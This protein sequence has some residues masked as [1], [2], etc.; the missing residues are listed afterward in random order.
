MIAPLTSWS[1]G[2]DLGQR[3]DRSALATLS[4]DWSVQGRN[5][6]DWSW[7]RV[8]R[9][10][11]R[12]IERFPLGAPYLSFSEA[13]AQRY[14]HIAALTPALTQ[15]QIHL[16]VDAGGPGAP[17]IEHLR[18]ARLR[19][20]L[21]AI[22]LT[23]GREPG[24]TA[25]GTLTVPRRVLLSN[26]ILLLDHGRLH[27][28]HDLPGWP[29]LYEELL[30]L[31][32]ATWHPDKSTAHDDMVIALAIAAWRITRLHPELLPEPANA[33]ARWEPTGYLF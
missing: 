25:A 5:P 9:L 27:A 11:L 17:V 2:F 4:L 15:P 18:R 16:T 22:L 14:R 33:P 1:L 31:N 20:D 6:V 30:A 29:L 7:I 10:V 23:G 19:M 8:P 12:D 21:K 3:S 13:L 24:A 32:A 28:P 26:L